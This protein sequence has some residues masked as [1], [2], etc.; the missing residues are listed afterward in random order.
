MYEGIEI[1]DKLICIK[2]GRKCLVEGEIYTIEYI[3]ISRFGVTIK[4]VE[5]SYLT[6]GVFRLDSFKP[7]F[8]LKKIRKIK[9]RICSK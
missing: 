3:Y 1:G 2:P 4:L 9:E 6:Y 5:R 7:E 8:R